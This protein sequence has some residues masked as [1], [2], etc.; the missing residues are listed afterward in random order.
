MEERERIL[1]MLSENKISVKEAEKLLKAVGD[2]K[3]STKKG[4]SIKEKKSSVKK[5]DGK[6]KIIVESE[7]GDNVNISVPLKLA[8]MVGKLMPGSAKEELE[9]E[10]IDIGALVSGLGDA[11]DDFDEDI[12]NINSSD[13]DKVRI[14]IEK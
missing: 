1:N 8:G 6:L 12:V 4:T 2:K 7:D 9:N 11:I 14:Y 10:G 13:G 5:L 3:E